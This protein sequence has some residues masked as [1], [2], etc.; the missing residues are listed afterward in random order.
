MAQNHVLD[1]LEGDTADPRAWKSG[2]YLGQH[3]DFDTVPVWR[4]SVIP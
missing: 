3:V 2:E 4:Y 1:I